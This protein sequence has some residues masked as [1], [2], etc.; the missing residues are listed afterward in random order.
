MHKK[1][2]GE[3][4]ADFRRFEPSL[5]IKPDKGIDAC[6]LTMQVCSCYVPHENCSAVHILTCNHL[7]R[8]W[9]FFVFCGLERYV[10]RH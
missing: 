2:I 10:T 8:F 1:N 7:V 9:C 5:H 6:L 4:A 3:A